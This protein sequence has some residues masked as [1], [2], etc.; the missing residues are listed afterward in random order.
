MRLACILLMSLFTLACGAGSADP[1][2]GL[3]AGFVFTPPSI[4]ALSPSS[5][6]LNSAPF[7]MTVTG[8]NFGT[9]AV[10]F[11]SG[12]AQQTTVVSS[13]QLLVSVTETDLLFTGLAHI[14]V[15]TGGMNS[16]TVD[17]NVAPQ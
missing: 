12:A 17:F 1:R 2:H 6:P 10:V 9:D 15:R 8:T 14:F 3:R 11:W 4:A 5:V 16:N 7:T 13:S